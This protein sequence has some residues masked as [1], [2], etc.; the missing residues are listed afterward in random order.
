[1]WGIAKTEQR[2]RTTKTKR[3]SARKSKGPRSF[4]GILEKKTQAYL[5]LSSGGR[6]RVG[7]TAEWSVVCS[8]WVRSLELEK[9]G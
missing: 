9:Q 5:R 8:V 4:M 6:E 1:M 3:L 2:D 7:E